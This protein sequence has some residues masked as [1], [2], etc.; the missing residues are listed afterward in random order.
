MCKKK[1]PHTGGIKAKK[2]GC[3]GEQPIAGGA[4]GIVTQGQRPLT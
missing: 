2:A 3:I 1:R 4:A